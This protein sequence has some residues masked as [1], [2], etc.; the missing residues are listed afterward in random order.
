MGNVTVFR[1]W[2]NVPEEEYVRAC[3]LSQH[4]D[5]IRWLPND[6]DAA[7]I[8]RCNPSLTVL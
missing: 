2:D 8:V 6:D 3:Y 1:D 7:H 4:P 5:A